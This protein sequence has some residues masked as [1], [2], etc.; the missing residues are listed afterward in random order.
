MNTLQAIMIAILQGA[1]E[2]FPISSLGHAVV[3]P[4]LLNWNLDQKSPEFL[5]FLVLLHTGTALA[6]LLYFWRDWLGLL[7]G[8][9]GAGG[10]TRVA[11]ARRLFLLIVVA[12][13]P[14]VILGYVFNHFFRALFATPVLAAGFLAVNGLMLLFGERLRGTA[15]GD[16]PMGAMTMTDAVTIGMWQCGALFPGISRAGATIVGGLL[17]GLNHE[18]SAHFS[19]L[20]ALPI[21]IGATVLEVPHLLHASVPPGVFQQAAIAAV[22]AGVTAFLA[23]AFLMRYFRR[24]D[25][26]ALNPFAF[27]CLI[28]GLG[29]VA[30]LVT[31]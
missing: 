27:Y 13:I 7:T 1:T 28:V 25:D 3:L 29:S 17:R 14:A 30:Y 21:I 19:F 5:P 10:A 23:T 24:H 6:L 4:A 16:K 12:T 15:R 22:A 11:E 26:W 9:L 8:V 18:S 2:L 31:R 20:I